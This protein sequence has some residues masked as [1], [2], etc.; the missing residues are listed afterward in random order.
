MDALGLWPKYDKAYSPCIPRANCNFF[1]D[2]G[3]LPLR[4]RASETQQQNQHFEISDRLLKSMGVHVDYK[5]RLLACMP[6][7]CVSAAVMVK[8]REGLKSLSASSTDCC[9]VCML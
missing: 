4:G 1:L 3:K 9:T 2:G 7:V 6:S 8:R 5:T